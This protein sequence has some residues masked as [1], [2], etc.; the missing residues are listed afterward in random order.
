MYVHV[1]INSYTPQDSTMW[2]LTQLYLV[3]EQEKKR[4]NTPYSVP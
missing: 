4:M 2:Q 3:I 1:V